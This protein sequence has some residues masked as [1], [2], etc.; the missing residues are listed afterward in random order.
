[1]VH[2]SVP[3]AAHYTGGFG[4]SAVGG[5]RRPHSSAQFR[6]EVPRMPGIVRNWGLIAFRARARD[7][8]RSGPKFARPAVVS[9]GRP[10][11]GRRG[12]HADLVG[13]GLG[14]WPGGPPW[15]WGG[16]QCPRG[17]EPLAAALPAPHGVWDAG[18]SAPP[19]ALRGL[20]SVAAI[21]RLSGQV[22]SCAGHRSAVLS[23]QPPAL[24]TAAGSSC[25]SVTE[26]AVEVSALAAPAHLPKSSGL[27][28][29]RRLRDRHASTL[30][31]SPWR[32]AWGRP[33]GRA[34]APG[35]RRRQACVQSEPSLRREV[36]RVASC[37]AAWRGRR[38]SQ[39]RS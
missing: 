17:G 32:R 35:T 28:S 5:C 12:P 29:Y 10:G 34:G 22:R 24:S 8:A 3:L 30:S 36:R 1:M 11:G 9:G 18:G 21:G 15:L 20:T 27:T 7:C 19:R 25:L 4:M 14:P 6:T 33:L 16:V 31:P 37:G 39:R 23:G 2:G 26:G 38:G 13:L